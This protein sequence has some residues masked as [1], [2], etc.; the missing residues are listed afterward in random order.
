MTQKRGF[1]LNGIHQYQ[2]TGW[3]FSRGDRRLNKT[4]SLHI[5]KV[6]L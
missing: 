3:N 1:N 4:L 6:P 5:K 2:F